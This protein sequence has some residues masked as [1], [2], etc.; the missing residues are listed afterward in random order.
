MRASKDASG[1][2]VLDCDRGGAAGKE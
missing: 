2:T 1:K